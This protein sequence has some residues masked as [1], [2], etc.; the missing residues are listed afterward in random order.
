MES[1][2]INGSVA[3]P[4]FLKPEG[5]VVFHVAAGKLFKATLESDEKAKGQVN[6]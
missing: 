6:G 5:I 3:V 2:R 4:G 1:L